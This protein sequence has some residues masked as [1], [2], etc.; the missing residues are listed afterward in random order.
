[1]VSHTEEL[2]FEAAAEI[3]DIK[4]TTLEAKMARL[5]LAGPEKRGE[6]NVEKSV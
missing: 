6:A 5:G 1:M 2:P 3:L 4:A